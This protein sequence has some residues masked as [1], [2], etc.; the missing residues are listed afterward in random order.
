MGVVDHRG[1]RGRTRRRCAASSCGTTASV[2][3]PDAAVAR[4]EIIRERRRRELHHPAPCSSSSGGRYRRAERLRRWTSRTPRSSPRCRIS[5]RAYAH[6]I[7]RRDFDGFAELFTEDAEFSLG[8]DGAQRTRRDPD[9]MRGVMKAPAA[10]TSSPTSACAPQG[11]D[12][13]SAVADYLLTRRTE[14]DGPWRNRRRRLV[15]VGG[16]LAATASGASPSTGSSP[17]VSDDEPVTYGERIAAA[18]RARTPPSPVLR[19]V[20]IDGAETVVTWPE[21]HRRSTQIA[22][23]LQSAGAAPGDPRRRRPAQLARVRD[24]RAGGV[25]ARRGAGAG[26]LGP[27][28]LGARA[29][30]RGDRR[31]LASAPT[32]SP[33]LEATADDDPTPLPPVVSPQTNGICSSGSTGAAKVILMDKPGV[34]DEMVGMPFAA[35]WGPVA[36]PQI[37]LVMA[38]MYHTNGFATLFSLLAGDHLVV[39]AEV[40]RRADRRPDRGPRRHHLHRD[41][42][43]APTH[44]RPARG[45]RARSLEHRVDPA[46]RGGHLAVAGAPLDRPG[47]RRDGSTSRTA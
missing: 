27:P 20:A 29:R 39:L 33:W 1:R 36:R 10:R 4:L 15:R 13:W 26:A 22:R 12:R 45:R 43:D 37:V 47:R 42:V 11:K 31:R 34:F 38:P 28:R 23:A 25:E 7:D 6:R 3:K 16:D 8:D 44:R 32:T 19:V 9:F 21:L 24:D 14:T 41:H 35:T 40:R 30:A 46:G 5:S 2:W 17:A 18:R